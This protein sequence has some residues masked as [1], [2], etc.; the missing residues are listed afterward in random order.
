MRQ[1]KIQTHKGKICVTDPRRLGRV[2]EAESATRGVLDGAT[3]DPQIRVDSVLR[4]EG[5]GNTH[6]PFH[7]SG[8]V[9]KY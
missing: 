4:S 6:A 5:Q 2:G 7:D 9:N 1:K 8:D 3:F